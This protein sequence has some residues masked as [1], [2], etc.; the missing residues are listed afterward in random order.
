MSSRLKVV[1]LTTSFFLF[2]NVVLADPSLSVSERVDKTLSHMTRAQLEAV[3][4]THLPAMMQHPSVAGRYAQGAG[5]SAALSDVQIPEITETDGTIGIGARVMDERYASTAYPAALASASSWNPTLLQELG[6]SVGRDASNRG[7]NILLSG[8]TNLTRDPRGGRNFEYLG[9]DPLLVG[10]LAG[11][12]T[13][14][15]QTNH[16]LATVKHFALNDYET[17]RTQYNVLISRKGAMESDLLAFD[18]ALKLGKP[19]AVMCA[20]SQV[21]GD[22]TCE[23][24]VL[25]QDILRDQWHYHG[26]VMSDWGAV[27]S[28]RKAIQAGLNQ[29]SGAELD[30]AMSLGGSGMLQNVDLP[31]STQTRIAS[32]KANG[33]LFRNAFFAPPQL[34]G[35][36]SDDQLRGMARPILTS[37]FST[38]VDEIRL[39]KPVD[40]KAGYQTALHAAQQGIVLLKN[41]SRTLP[42]D[43]KSKRIVV[44][45]GHADV[46]VLSGGGSPSVLPFGG[47]AVPIAGENAMAT[48]IW[49]PSSPLE[50]MR[51]LAPTSSISYF[52]E[53]DQE[54]AVQAAQTA[55]DVVVFVP[56]WSLEGRDRANLSLTEEQNQL[57]EAVA[58]VNPHVT[59]VLET[60]GAV[61]MPWLDRVSAVVE[62]WY[63]GIA[64]GQA[65]AQILF[66]DVNPSGH[67]PLT[68][69]LSEQEL[70]R[71]ELPKAPPL[72][73]DGRPHTFPLVFNE[74]ENVGYKW[75]IKTGKP[76]LFPFGFGLSYTH[77][78]YS[79]LNVMPDEPWDINVRVKNDGERSGSDVV[80]VYADGNRLIKRLVGWKRVD[81]MGHQSTEVSIHIDPK[82]IA[83]FSEQD[84]QWHV[85]AGTYRLTAASS[86]NDPGITAHLIVKDM[87]FGD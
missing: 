65:I 49:D 13:H 44:I 69:P 63:P 66:G 75:F 35:V 61:L 19:G 43:K 22:Y 41:N 2:P 40:K 23:S 62:A 51:R 38:G 59:V 79:H 52:S 47:N 48:Q 12:Y 17:A 5:W 25:L 37:W 15:A 28:T 27:H 18:I 64:G 54:K 10:T 85:V 9:E 11:W 3:I 74:E 45:G 81:L 57:I 56:Q 7:F 76:V 34:Q 14:G 50:E 6:Y 46:G 30:Y 16:I 58:H 42:L 20:Y 26:Y 21:W 55:D 1:L 36:V 68:F 70:P 82:M 86:V 72:P 29:E 8:G 77:F 80:Q 31:P 32:A 53:Q 71:P 78:A 33:I 39:R 84:N 73:L 87:A 60:E 67:L 83:K 24:K 4:V